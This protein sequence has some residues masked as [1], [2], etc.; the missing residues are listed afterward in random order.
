[1]ATAE[2]ALRILSLGAGIQSTVL[3]LLAVEGVLPK[4]D[5]AIFA[6]TGWEPRAVYDH[7]D[8]LEKVL[9]GAGIPLMRVS[10]GNLRDDT[11]DPDV[12]GIK[13]PV[14]IRSSNVREARGAML[15]RQCTS[16]YKLDPINRQIRRMLG[17][18]VAS[19]PC[20][21]CEGRGLRI[22]PQSKHG[23]GE[24]EGPCSVCRGTG[25][26][27]RVGSPPK[28]RCA[29]QWVGFSVDEIGRV[30]PSRVPYVTS[31]FPLLDLGMSRKDCERWLTA[32]GWQVAKSACIACPYHGNR[33]WRDLR[34]NHPG[35]WADAV[36]FD[37][38]LRTMPGSAR[39][40]GAEAFVHASRLPLDQAPIDRVT[41]REWKDR[42]G[43]IFDAIADAELEEEGDPD[44]CSP[45]GCRSGEA[46]T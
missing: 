32:R 8:L 39:R 20:R 5:A 37:R 26:V 6:D 3:A 33:M 36:D 7:L 2:P 40:R 45:F 27:E 13:I 1:M 31:T 41:S 25:Q 42:Q 12:P 30:S 11:L 29:E 34:D 35:E 16:S 46:A 21:H 22:V 28:G 10:Q 9:T 38:Q 4:P 43:D 17:A 23:G 15:T 24:R 18:R 44:G 19:G 14:F